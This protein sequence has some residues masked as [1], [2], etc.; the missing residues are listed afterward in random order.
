[1]VRKLVYR[2]EDEKGFGPFY[3]AW[4]LKG[5]DGYRDCLGSEETL[6]EWFSSRGIVVDKSKYHIGVY[7]VDFPCEAY[8]NGLPGTTHLFFKTDWIVEK[9]N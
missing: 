3:N 4:K 9:I 6:E 1:M 8:A 7:L 5:D 2:Y